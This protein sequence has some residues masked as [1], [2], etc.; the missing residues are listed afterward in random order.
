MS[1][2]SPGSRS[3]KRRRTVTDAQSTRV[4]SRYDEE[5]LEV[6]PAAALVEIYARSGYDGPDT[7]VLRSTD[8]RTP[9]AC[10]YWKEI[11]VRE[12]A[13]EGELI[14]CAFT[15]AEQEGT[16]KTKGE[17]SDR[18]YT[19][20][21]R[22]TGEEKREFLLF[23]ST[24]YD[25][26]WTVGKSR[27]VAATMATVRFRECS[28]I[29]FPGEGRLEVDLPDPLAGAYEPFREHAG[30]HYPVPDP[31]TSVPVKSRSSSGNAS[32]EESADSTSSGRGSS[33]E[34]PV[35]G[36]PPPETDPPPGDRWI[37]LYSLAESEGDGAYSSPSLLG[38][39][40][41]TT[42]G[43]YERASLEEET[44]TA[45]GDPQTAVLVPTGHVG[46]GEIGMYARLAL[47]TP[48]TERLKQGGRLL[49]HPP[50]GRQSLSP[51]T[52]PLFYH[53]PVPGTPPTP[54]THGPHPV[55]P[56]TSVR[57]DDVTAHLGHDE[58]GRPVYLINPL[59]VAQ[60]RVS[61][62]EAA[63]DAERTWLQRVGWASGPSGMVS[64]LCYE[65]VHD[66]TY[67][68]DNLKS[69][70][71]AT[72]VAERDA[73][74]RS[75]RRV[76]PA[77]NVKARWAPFSPDQVYGTGEQALGSE[78]E[79]DLL[80][81]FR[82]GVESKRAFLLWNRRRAARRARTLLGSAYL[83]QTVLDLYSAP[84]PNETLTNRLLD[85]F[86]RHALS[87]GVAPFEEAGPAFEDAVA[88]DG[89][90]GAA[91]LRAVAGRTLF[92]VLLK[93]GKKGA[94]HKLAVAAA[95]QVLAEWSG[96]ESGP[97]TGMEALAGLL[98]RSSHADY[99]VSRESGRIRFRKNGTTE[100]EIAKKT[101][102][103]EGGG[104]R[105][106]VLRVDGTVKR[107]AEEATESISSTTLGNGTAVLRVVEMVA[108]G[109]GVVQSLQEGDFG[110]ED[111]IATAKV[112]VDL[113][114]LA[115]ESTTYT[116]LMKG[117]LP[118]GLSTALGVVG[119]MLDTIEG[120]VGGYLSATDTD[121]RGQATV[122][123]P[124]YLGTIGNAVGLGTGII[125]TVTEG[126]PAVVIASVGVL[127]SS[128]TSAA[129]EVWDQWKK[130]AAD[131]LSDWVAY[132]SLW[133]Q[134]FSAGGA[135]SSRAALMK[136][137]QP[138]GSDGTDPT[139]QVLRG[140]TDRKT[141]PEAL[142]DEAKLIVEEG[143][144]FP[145]SVTVRHGPDAF[146]KQGPPQVVSLHVGYGYLP[147]YGTLMVDAN[148]IP[149]TQGMVEKSIQCAIHYVD[150]DG[151]VR[152]RVRS[153]ADGRAQPIE[154]LGRNETLLDRARSTG[155][156][157]AGA[158]TFE[159][160]GGE[161][162]EGSLFSVRI[163]TAWSAYDPSEDSV[164][165]ADATGLAQPEV[166]AAEGAFRADPQAIIEGPSGLEE[167]L[168]TRQFRVTGYV[169]FRPLQP[170]NLN[171]DIP[172]GTPD[173]SD[174]MLAWSQI[175]YEHPE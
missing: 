45:T 159:G 22:P 41:A 133:G 43:K 54:K 171:P 32:G 14:E 147:S 163:G 138:G 82:R 140:Q 30:N 11:S 101:V 137:V 112:P 96:G 39:Y 157:H 146:S 86:P 169:S 130:E 51:A 8:G 50:M 55:D 87:G 141:L 64:G 128:A 65:G 13:A 10:T 85:L 15:L 5:V 60:R 28:Q 74:D 57:V 95:P 7:L 165:P 142:V 49:Q 98:M 90:E 150:A 108:T 34:G 84:S 115:S 94:A 3:K 99:E 129:D 160:H 29:T 118:S 17:L 38:T 62:V 151:E 166:D 92:N 70:M 170:F 21:W 46:A 121:P 63:A 139:E 75:G 18:T 114:T 73:D 134:D 61:A 97:P 44:P 144:S 123:D 119:P 48:S 154:P 69:V 158:G 2:S 148:L 16:A 162:L 52:T 40:R 88:E 24:P 71:E 80:G 31:N 110:V 1:A 135:A 56:S 175:K 42:D 83:F 6:T 53:Q 156:A 37:V 174:R 145:T 106:W 77:F 143:F 58:P 122:D 161:A 9:S 19:L 136:A 173:T 91:S 132:G 152:Y 66:R 23:E 109:T 116:D 124:N 33:A 27:S 126:A 153:V 117:R 4:D 59:W 104:A 93:V 36:V 25:D 72:P 103:P 47:G 113:A 164:A 20:G 67:L 149:A 102:D 81:Q 105:R 68:A 125:A 168:E 76:N 26:V 111:V 100:V 120:I 172:E 78:T 12:Q 89:G 79:K 107:E 131:P 167:I 155:W 35:P 127:V